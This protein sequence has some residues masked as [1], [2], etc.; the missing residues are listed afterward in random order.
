MQ[1]GTNELSL[2]CTFPEDGASVGMKGNHYSCSFQGDLVE[3][4]ALVDFPR[5]VHASAVVGT[6]VPTGAQQWA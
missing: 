2:P 6:S 1:Q 5:V 3:A 4:L